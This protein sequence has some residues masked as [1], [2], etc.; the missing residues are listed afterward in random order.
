MVAQLAQQ[1]AQLDAQKAQLQGQLN[2]LQQMRLAAY[3][4]TSSGTGKYRPVTCPQ[5]YTGDAG[6]KA[7]KFACAQIG[8]KYVWAADGPDSY[9]CSGLTLAAWRSV[10]VSLP[11]NAYEQKQVTKS[12]S[13]ASLKP[14]DLVFYYSDVHHVVI[15]IGNGY[16]VSAP[17]F[18]E[19]VQEQKI[20]MSRVNGYGR[21]G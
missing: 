14:G 8:K 16:V 6:S 13:F 2:Q 3:G 15:Y 18:G 19:P 5:V 11:H 4:D 12:V 10:G 21:P 20:D 17:T 9:D 1:Q 7:A